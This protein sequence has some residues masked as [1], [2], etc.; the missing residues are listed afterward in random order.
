MDLTTQLHSDIIQF[1]FN[2]FIKATF[3]TY[4]V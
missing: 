2:K 1:G 4:N 3:K